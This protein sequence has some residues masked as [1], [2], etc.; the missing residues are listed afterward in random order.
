M[1]TTVVDHFAVQKDK[2]KKETKENKKTT[3]Q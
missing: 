1:K 3:K 2:Y